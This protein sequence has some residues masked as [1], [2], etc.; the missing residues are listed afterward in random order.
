MTNLTHR[1]P[2]PSRQPHWSLQVGHLVVLMKASG[3]LGAG[4]LCV[5]D[6]GRER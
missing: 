4:F 2:S 5:S 3:R 6:E 1:K